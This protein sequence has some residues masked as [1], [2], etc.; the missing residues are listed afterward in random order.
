MIPRRRALWDVA[1]LALLASCASRN[2]LAPDA[3]V[4]G[5][6]SDAASN[7][8][9]CI[10]GVR[11]TAC[12]WPAGTDAAAPSED[13]SSGVVVDAGLPPDATVSPGDAM[14]TGDAARPG[15]DAAVPDSGTGSCQPM[16]GGTG[17][18]RLVSM[19]PSLIPAHGLTWVTVKYEGDAPETSLLFAKAGGPNLQ[20]MPDRSTS[21]FRFSIGGSTSLEPIRVSVSV[22][23]INPVEIAWLNCA[24]RFVRA[25]AKAVLRLSGYQRLSVPLHPELDRRCAR[26]DYFT[27]S[28]E[29]DNLL[30]TRQV[31]F[32]RVDGFT[33]IGDACSPRMLAYGEECGLQVCFTSTT[34][35]RHETTLTVGTNGGDVQTALVG[36]V[37]PATPGLDPGFGR[38]GGVSLTRSDGSASLRGVYIATL[39]NTDSTVAVSD[40]TFGFQFV[41]AAGPWAPAVGDA[42]LVNGSYLGSMRAL[43]AGGPGQG[44]YALVGPGSSSNPAALIRFFDDGTRDLSFAGTG[45]VNLEA[46]VSLPYAGIQVQA[47][48]RVLVIATYYEMAGV[49]AF[50]PGGQE[51]QAYR[52]NFANQGVS[53]IDDRG[54]LYVTTAA[55]VVRLKPDGGLDPGFTFS[56]AIEAMTV[57]RNQRLLV[58]AAGKLARLDDAGVATAVPLGSQPELAK[59]IAGIDV[60]AAGRILLTASGGAVLRYLDDGRFDARLGFADG[61]AREVV[62]PR[63][64]GCSI[65]GTVGASGEDYVL[66]LA[67]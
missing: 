66:R 10:R 37:L 61:G 25:P 40:G 60:D 39:S 12:A 48:G 53:A 59:P 56:G 3:T 49:R 35:G 67:P 63:A 65:A 4:S 41:S 44:I 15:V 38:S 21:S 55:G 23:F 45:A 18:M 47:S 30:S 57:D 54:R 16:G 11:E 34:P 1:A 7:L 28:N 17:S 6:P 5:N 14:P 43:R 26:S 20:I 52:T 8:P 46:Y 62:C 24:G 64:G 29:G 58:V 9:A 22:G 27:L 42:P 36:E 13:A 2:P 50:S 51:D 19:E 33:L 31:T 32:T